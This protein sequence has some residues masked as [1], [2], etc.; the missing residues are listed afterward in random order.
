MV[1]YNINSVI[2]IYGIENIFFFDAPSLH[3]TQIIHSIQV[4]KLGIILH[5][6]EIIYLEKT[7]WYKISIDSKYCGWIEHL[8][9]QKIRLT[10]GPFLDHVN[11][12]RK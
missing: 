7:A 6:N 8:Q 4:G 11:K 12:Y 3:E 2:P 1:Y 5:I 9:L 10:S